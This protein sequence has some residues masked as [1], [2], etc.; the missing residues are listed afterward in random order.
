VAAVQVKATDASRRARTT[1]FAGWALV[2]AVTASHGAFLA[3]LVP[4]FQSPDEPA[5]FD[6][7]QRLAEARRLPEKRVHCPPFSAEVRAVEAAVHRVAFRPERSMPPL[8]E[9]R[10]PEPTPESRATT[11]CSPSTAYPPLYYATVAAAYAAG[12]D[13]T[14]LER[15]HASRLASVAWAIVGA[16][17][18]FLLGARLLGGAVGG[19]LLGMTYAL[20]PMIAMLS[21][22]VNNDAAIVACAAAAFAAIAYLPGSDRPGAPLTVLALATTA[23]VLS[24]PTFLLAVPAMF[25]LA[26]LALGPRRRA[27]WALAIAAFLPAAIAHLAWS[28]YAAPITADLFS[29]GGTSIA[30]RTYLR[31]WVLRPGRIEAVWVKSYWMTWGWLDTPVAR[32]YYGAIELAL[33]LAVLGLALGWKSVARA[34]RWIVGVGVAATIAYA[35]ALYVMEL[36]MMRHTPFQGLLQGRYLLPLYPLHAILLVVGLR[37]LAAR[38]RVR[39]DPAWMF[40]ALLAVVNTASIATALARYHA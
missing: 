15:L 8:Q 27:A 33:L 24:K 3:A 37:A 5:H 28:A 20:Q 7:A 17:A 10:L 30:L 31:E 23:G 4:P 29:G 12:R 9:I 38:F 32:A 39:F 13:G 25:A 22:T 36:W 19:V 21:A 35:G 6:Y 14:F 34:E 2:V 11:G 26:V 16:T 1:A 18:A 40:P